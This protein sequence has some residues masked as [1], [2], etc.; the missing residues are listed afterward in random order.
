MTSPATTPETDPQNDTAEQL[1]L[2]AIAGY[3][4]ASAAGDILAPA[5]LV[6]RMA[7]LGIP[8]RAARAALELGLSIGR[9]T[10]EVPTGPGRRARRAT[11]TREPMYRAAYLLHAARRLG[12]ALQAGRWDDAL[13]AERRYLA[14]HVAAAA[15]RRR[16]AVDVDALV[17]RVGSPWLIWRTQ[18]DGRVDVDCTRLEGVVFHVDAPPGGRYPGAEHPNCRCHAEQAPFGLLQLPEV[19]GLRNR[20]AP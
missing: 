17:E 2:A 12:R 14:Q 4:A 1:L 16:A 13:T 5:V 20:R 7:G 10:P 19:F 6:S 15:K 9:R 18:R 3:L 8:R 11:A